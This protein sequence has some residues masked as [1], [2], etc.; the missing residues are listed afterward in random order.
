MGSRPMTNDEHMDRLVRYLRL[1][2]AGGNQ[3]K[4]RLKRKR[5]IDE[6]LATLLEMKKRWKEER[7]T[8]EN[9]ENS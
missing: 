9:E 6:K 1:F 2:L 8:R 7:R 4:R 5:E 3:E